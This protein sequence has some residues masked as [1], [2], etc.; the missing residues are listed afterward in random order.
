MLNVTC[1][2]DGKSGWQQHH[3]LCCCPGGRG[4]PQG[5]RHRG[6]WG[7][8][9]VQCCNSVRNNH[10]TSLYF[11]MQAPLGRSANSFRLNFSNLE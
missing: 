3:I 4:E 1:K 8:Q 11:F 10:E 5:P 2:Q 9:V 7:A 6:H